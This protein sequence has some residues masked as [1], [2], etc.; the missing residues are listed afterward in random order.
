MLQACEILDAPGTLRSP[1]KLF[2]MK[3]LG[4]LLLMMLGELGAGAPLP[5]LLAAPGRCLA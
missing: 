1:L 3:M 5:R 4:G 2:V